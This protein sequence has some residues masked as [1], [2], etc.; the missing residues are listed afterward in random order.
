M[1]L[2]LIMSCMGMHCQQSTP[3]HTNIMDNG[4]F[5]QPVNKERKNNDNTR[6]SKYLDFLGFEKKIHQTSSL[7][8]LLL[9]VFRKCS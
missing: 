7:D 9:C 5:L 4:S 3:S 6:V 8:R 1:V 2:A